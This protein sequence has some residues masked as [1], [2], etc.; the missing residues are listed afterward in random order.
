PLSAMGK[1]GPITIEDVLKSK[2]IAEPLHL[3]DSCIINQGAGCLVVAAE[4]RIARDRPKVRMLGYG[5][6][7]GYLDPCS[8]PS[9]TTFA[10]GI[11]ADQAFTTAGIGRDEIDVVGMSDHFTINVLIGLEDAGFC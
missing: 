11:A 2:M 8:A 6:A 1:R 10:G 5:Q 9:M 3:L 4:D 7:H